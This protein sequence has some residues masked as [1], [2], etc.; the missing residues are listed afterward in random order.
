MILKLFFIIVV[1]LIGLFYIVAL[2]SFDSIVT[3]FPFYDGVYF[4]VNSEKQKNDVV[5]EYSISLNIHYP[6]VVVNLNNED[7]L[8]S[9]PLSPD[10]YRSTT[11]GNPST[12]FS[13]VG[14]DISYP[15]S[16]LTKELAATLQGSKATPFSFFE[17]SSKGTINIFLSNHEMKPVKPSLVL[18]KRA[19]SSSSS[20]SLSSL[21]SSSFLWN[22]ITTNLCTEKDILIGKW[23]YDKRRSLTKTISGYENCPKFRHTITE[24][25]LT[26]NLRYQL[27]FFYQ[28]NS[29]FVLPLELSMLLY[30]AIL[31]ENQQHSKLE[32]EK[33]KDHRL[34]QSRTT[35]SLDQVKDSNVVHQ[36]LKL[37]NIKSSTRI[38]SKLFSKKASSLQTS[39]KKDTSSVQNAVEKITKKE[40]KSMKRKERTS[41][42][43][44]STSP[45]DLFANI[46]PIQPLL[47]ENYSLPYI[48]F[49]G[50]SMVWQ[51]GEALTCEVEK[52]TSK[53]PTEMNKNL[54][55]YTFHPYLRQDFPCFSQCRNHSSSLY[56]E[57]IV[58]LSKPYYRKDPTRNFFD[59]NPC[60]GC[61]LVDSYHKNNSLSLS[62]NSNS[63][64]IQEVSTINKTDQ[65]ISYLKFLYPWIYDK[66]YGEEN[67]KTNILILGTGAWHD[68]Y[69]YIENSTNHF[70]SF[71]IEVFPLLKELQTNKRKDLLIFWVSLPT[72]FQTLSPTDEVLF[73]WESYSKKN[74]LL[75]TAITKYNKEME[76]EFLQQSGS[77]NRQSV[78]LHKMFYIDMETYASSRKFYEW[79][80]QK[81]F[82]HDHLH[83]IIPGSFSV[84]SFVFEIIFHLFIRYHLIND[85][86]IGG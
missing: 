13:F 17:V 23:K 37:S 40:K 62:V 32:E 1:C 8:Y 4:L 77:D 16:L 41:S 25:P 10:F 33:G 84:P 74:A 44:S 55:S 47:F 75:K 86:L 49:Y 59:H 73:E 54:F 43:S 36:K 15:A 5:S 12:S 80:T 56:A 65:Q 83:W 68:N 48:S 35:D 57:S 28:N 20:S 70:Q 51:L 31:Q 52:I 29:C 81:L 18:Q 22:E 66:Y 72:M 78:F 60:Y 26:V 6:F 2:E 42:I 39:E 30:H 45:K 53:F 34:L 24:S 7:L 67:E 58:R 79:K 69:N 11:T 19:I 27:P 50:D 71:L 76:T 14:K 61:Y 46:I 82:A 63:N 21:S 38:K 85:R 3:S 64:R 9:S